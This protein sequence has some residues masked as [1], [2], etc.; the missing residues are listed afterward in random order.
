MQVAIYALDLIYPKMNPL[1]HGWTR[2]DGSTSTKLP[3]KSN[4]VPAAVHDTN[5]GTSHLVK[6]NAS[7]HACLCASSTFLEQCRLSFRLGFTAMKHWC[8]LD[9]YFTYHHI[10]CV[11]VLLTALQGQHRAHI[12]SA[13]SILMLLTLACFWESVAIVDPHLWRFRGN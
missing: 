12:I 3:R 5:H 6:N 8:W 11:V 7:T 10:I 2:N 13:T 4:T 9:G 1:R